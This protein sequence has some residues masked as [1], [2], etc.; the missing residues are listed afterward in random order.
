MGKGRRY[1]CLQQ[2][3]ERLCR[4]RTAEKVALTLVAMLG[5]KKS[6]LLCCFDA[7]RNN[8]LLEAFTH[9]DHGTDNDGIVRVAGY[10]AHERLVNLQGIDMRR[11]IPQSSFCR[12]PGDCKHMHQIRRIPDA[13]FALLYAPIL[14]YP[15]SS[16]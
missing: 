12:M 1:T 7:L 4:H 2:D 3:S 15:R 8:V 9:A 14:T 13:R 5:Q 10:M 6:S 11:S 16:A